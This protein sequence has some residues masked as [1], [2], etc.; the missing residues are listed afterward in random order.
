MEDRGSAEPGVGASREKKAPGPAPS[1]PA[2]ARPPAQGWTGPIVA[3][4]YSPNKKPR[5]AR[6]K[7]LQR[8]STT[9]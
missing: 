8:I 6:L 3:Q 2:R 5:V 7:K 1:R 9:V 4:A